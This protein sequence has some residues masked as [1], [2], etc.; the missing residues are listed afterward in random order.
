MAKARGKNADLADYER[1][2][3]IEVV[4]GVMF[5]PLPAWKL[6][7]VGVFW[8]QIADEF[9]RCEHASPITARDDFID[10]ATGLPIPRVWLINAADDSLVQLQ[11]G[12]FLFNW[13]HRENAGPY[14]R[15][16]TL[17]GRFFQLFQEFRDFIAENQLGE[18][19]VLDYELTY[20]N[21]VFEQGGWTFPDN[22]GR[23]VEHLSWQA[24]R[25]HF[26]PP[27]LPITWQAGF[28]FSDGPGT[29]LVKLNRAKR[30]KDEKTLLVLE[31]SA[32]G[33]PTEAPLDNIERW[34]SHAHQ[35][36]VRGFEDITSE[37]AQKELWG[38]HE[39][40]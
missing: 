40:C 19:D 35:W 26:L 7:H 34:F 38:K 28:A 22:V 17:S 39:Q 4:Y 2:P 31:F 20:I 24:E 1:P 37:E 9:P 30:A 16:G 6:P 36:I 8:Q 23:V 29:L 11:P 3:V 14:P 5:A 21:H 27:P 13:R 18:I 33:L 10:P 15:Y 25:Y 12:R 32:H